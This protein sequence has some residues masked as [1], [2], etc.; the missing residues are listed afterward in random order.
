M[1]TKLP[2]GTCSVCATKTSVLVHCG[3]DT[4]PADI[5]DPPEDQRCDICGGICQLAEGYNHR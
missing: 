4:I 3:Y 2:P 1:E 5:M